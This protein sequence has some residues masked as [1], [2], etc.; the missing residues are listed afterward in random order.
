MHISS[1]IRLLTGNQLQSRL[2]R[3]QF[4][5]ICRLKMIKIL[6]LSSLIFVNAYSVQNIAKVVGGDIAAINAFPYQAALI[7]MKK[8]EFS[9]CCGSVI[10]SK[11]VLTGE[12]I[13]KK[14]TIFLICNFLISRPLLIQQDINVGSSWCSPCG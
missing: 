3:T 6:I 7:S 9:I 10:S 13:V 1:I 11:A 12:L 8:S 14:Q 4:S 2:D 5:F